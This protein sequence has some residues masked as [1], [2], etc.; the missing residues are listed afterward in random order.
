MASVTFFSFLCKALAPEGKFHSLSSIIRTTGNRQ[1]L[2]ALL[3]ATKLNTSREQYKPG[4]TLS[5]EAVIVNDCQPV[6]S[7]DSFISLSCTLVFDQL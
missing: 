4:V 6:T 2:M 3:R 7:L 1:K 5:Y